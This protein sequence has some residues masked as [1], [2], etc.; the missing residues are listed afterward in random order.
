VIAVALVALG[1]VA[2]GPADHNPP[3]VPDRAREAVLEGT[4]RDFRD[5]VGVPP[6]FPQCFVPALGRALTDKRLEALAVIHK[7]RGEPAAARA[8]NDLGAPVGDSCGGREWVPE[9]TTAA[10]GLRPAP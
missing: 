2:C 9:L 6:G 7:S 4:R 5:T 10:Q 3:R 8:L 1:L